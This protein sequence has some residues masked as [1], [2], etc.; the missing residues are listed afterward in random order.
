MQQFNNLRVV[1]TVHCTQAASS[2]VYIGLKKQV[3]EKRKS[4]PKP[5]EYSRERGHFEPPPLTEIFLTAASL[6]S[7]IPNFD[8]EQSSPPIWYRAVVYCPLAY[9]Y[10]AR[11]LQNLAT[12]SSRFDRMFEKLRGVQPSCKRFSICSPPIYVD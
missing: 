4:V 9:Q 7:Q 8:P 10:N 2:A 1:Y 5:R 11:F 12:V 6:N 3:H